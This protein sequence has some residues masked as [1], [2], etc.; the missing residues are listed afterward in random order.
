MKHEFNLKL[1]Q[2][3]AVFSEI[4]VPIADSATNCIACTKCLGIVHTRADAQ[5]FL[6]VIAMVPPRTRTPS[7]H[8]G[9]RVKPVTKPKTNATTQVSPL[10]F[11]FR[12]VSRETP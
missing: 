6:P 2:I 9:D 3:F 5:V 11:Q 4:D 8:I 7:R 1:T 10:I 12:R